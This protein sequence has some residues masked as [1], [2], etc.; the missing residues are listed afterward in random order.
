MKWSLLTRSSFPSI[1][2]TDVE[3]SASASM[4]TKGP[5]ALLYSLFCRSWLVV[6]T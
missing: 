6:E 1:S 2:M 4:T 3:A 5:M